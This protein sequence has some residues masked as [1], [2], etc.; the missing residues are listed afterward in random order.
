[1]PHQFFEIPKDD[2]WRLS[3]KSLSLSEDVSNWEIYDDNCKRSKVPLST[4]MINY[5]YNLTNLTYSIE[6]ND[7]VAHYVKYDIHDSYDVDPHDDH[8][9]ITIIVYL[10]KDDNISET[11]SI[12]HNE[13]NHD[14]WSTDSDKL[15][16]MVMWSDEDEFGPIHSVNMVGNGKRDI[17]CLFLG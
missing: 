13:I 2:F 15:T 3:N 9:K 14:Y 4:N 7:T 11:L 1:M 16:C 8:C 12:D 10:H 6:I 17:L 5:I